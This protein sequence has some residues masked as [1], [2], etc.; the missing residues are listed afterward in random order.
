MKHLIRCAAIGAIA[1]LAL[2]GCGP[3]GNGTNPAAAGKPAVD[4]T[5]KL[6]T[7]PVDRTKSIQ[8]AVG[9]ALQGLSA[10]LSGG[11]RATVIAAGPGKLLVYAPQDAQASIGETIESLG[12]AATQQVA[13]IQVG[14]HFWVIDGQPGS[15][16]DDP[17]LK[18]LAGNLASLRQ[19]MGPLHFRLDQVAALVGTSSEDGSLVTADGPYTR[20]FDF[21]IGTIRDDTARLQ[22]SYQDNGGH[23]LGKLDTHID[24]TFGQYIV[25]AQAPGACAQPSTNTSV[26][27]CPNKPAVRLLVVRVDRLPAKA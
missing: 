12:K 21:H 20:S 3:H 16:D 18:T 11:A 25:L 17:S 8:T 10:V 1:L 24:A 7:V 27:T 15:G 2:A 23:G 26:A 4:L 14:V 13:P 22:L 19:A 5:L 6:Y 9:E